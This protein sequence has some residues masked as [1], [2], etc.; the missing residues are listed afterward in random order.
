VVTTGPLS[1]GG[2]S[3]QIDLGCLLGEYQTT[4]SR[5]CGNGNSVKLIGVDS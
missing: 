4:N 2:V 1:F 5:V 3:I